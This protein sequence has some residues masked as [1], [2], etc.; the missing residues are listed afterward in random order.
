VPS[1]LISQLLRSP[2]PHAFAPQRCRED[3]D[4]TPRS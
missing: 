3:E 4:H 2:L 1:L